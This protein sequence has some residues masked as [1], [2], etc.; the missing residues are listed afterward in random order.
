METMQTIPANID[1]PHLPPKRRPAPFDKNLSRKKV[2]D[3]HANK[4]APDLSR[5]SRMVQYSQCVMV[6]P[7]PPVEVSLNIQPLSLFWA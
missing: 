4:A 7:T 1:T 6:F 2:T 3:T 5:G